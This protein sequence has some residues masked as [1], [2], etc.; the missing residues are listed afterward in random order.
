M[1][2]HATHITP[3]SKNN[4]D[5][6]HLHALI[7]HFTFHL[8]C[9]AENVIHLF[10]SSQPLSTI[11]PNLLALVPRLISSAWRP[12]HSTLY[13]NKL[14]DVEKWEE[15]SLPGPIRDRNPFAVPFPMPNMAEESRREIYTGRYHPSTCVPIPLRQRIQCTVCIATQLISHAP[16]SPSLK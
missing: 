11:S 13:Y 16:P 14:E 15:L 9:E 12:D 6:Q 4:P 10:L 8:T 2:W 7:S 3:A 5:G 1:G